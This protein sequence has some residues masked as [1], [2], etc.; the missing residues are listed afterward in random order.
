MAFEPRSK[1]MFRRRE[2]EGAGEGWS[3]L[4]TALEAALAPFRAGRSDLGVLFSGGVDSALL[5]WELRRCPGLTLSTVGTPHSPDLSAAEAGA[6]VL[7]VPWRPV[8]VGNAEV[9]EL[10]R[11]LEDETRGQSPVARSVQVA[12][13]LAVQRAPARE[14]LCGQGA[15]ELFLGYA[16]YRGLS[17]SEA[18]HRSE[19]DLERVLEEDWP[20]SQRIARRWGKTVEAPYLDRRFIEAVLRVPIARRLPQPVPKAFLRAWARHRGLPEVLAE[21]PKRALQ[22]GSGVDRILRRGR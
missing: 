7:G 17:P 9:L 6:A 8:T 21:R 1:R 22:F 19:Q 2:A 4:D 20:R 15:D 13:A 5:A 10:A 18:Q 3:D 11:E 12:F 14:L 16:H